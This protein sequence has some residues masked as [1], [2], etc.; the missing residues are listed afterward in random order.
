MSATFNLDTAVGFATGGQRALVMRI[1]NTS[2]VERGAD[3]SFLSCFPHEEESL[4][5]PFTYMKVKKTS[6]APATVT[7]GGGVEL[8][9]L[10][11]ET[12]TLI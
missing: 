3:L 4:F 2:Y 9:V 11:I 10:D 12:Q 5:P 6:G 7:T 8:K 1:H